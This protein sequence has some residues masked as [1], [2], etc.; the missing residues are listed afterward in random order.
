MKIA[1]YSDTHGLA[2]TVLDKYKSETG[3]NK[4]KI[5]VEPVDLV[6]LL[7][8][9]SEA[10]VKL[11]EAHY[12]NTN[13]I[14]IYGNHDIFDLYK[15]TKIINM[16]KSIYNQGN[17]YFTGFQGSNR[18]KESQVYGYSQSESIAECKK[19]PKVNILLSHSGPFGD[20]YRFVDD[21]HCGLKGLNKYLKK[22]SPKIMLFGHH[23]EDLHFRL[24][25]TDCYCI[26]GC[27]IITIEMDRVI[28]IKRYEYD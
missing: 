25:N 6:C 7:G 24:Y 4:E 19:L 8:D 9:H 28:D 2:K 23:H 5:S 3:Y 11:I 16:H 20:Y 14:G 1:V 15:G 17:Y 13:I 10:D 27:A 18:Y 12:P 22:N 26:Y 21:A